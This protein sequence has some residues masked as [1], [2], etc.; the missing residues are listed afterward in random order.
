[1]LAALNPSARLKVN[2]DTFCIPDS[3]GSVYFRNNRV[4][5]R[6]EG[7]TIDQWIEKLIP[8]FHGGH[9]LGELT[10]G[11]PE[12]H[13]NQIYGIAET[14]YQNGFVRDVSG[15]LPHDLREPVLGRYASQIE[16]LDSLGGSGAHR[17]QAFRQSRVLAAG[18]GPMLVSLAAA[19]FESGL[20]RVHLLPVGPDPVNRPRLAE[21]TAHARRT[22]PEAEL[23]LTRPAGKDPDSWR[24]TI[25]PFDAVLYAAHEPDLKELRSLHAACRAERKALLPAIFL[26]QAGLAG[27]QVHPDSE[28]CWESAL[29]RL[30]R[31][32]LEKE[33]AQSPFSS[34]AG[35]LLANLI[36]FEWLKTAAGVNEP[37]R[38]RAF[39]LLDPETLEGEWHTF[40]PHPLAAGASA[41]A[42]IEKIGERLGP[43]T[44]REDFEA[45]RLL[46]YFASLTS[47]AAGILHLW[48]EEDLRQ[49]PLALC[50]V[51]AADPL[52]EGPAGLLPDTICSALTHEAARREAG[53]AGIEAYCARLAE[54]FA[55]EH[56]SGS[57]PAALAPDSRP[58]FGVG[59]G[60]TFA[61]GVCRGLSKCLA[62]LLGRPCLRM[63][64]VS[65]IR[66]GNVEDA[67]CRYFLRALAAMRGEPVI[68]LG[69]ETCG[70]PVVWIG[71]GGSW[72]KS[73]GL[74]LTLALRQALQQA[75]LELQLPS[76][77]RP[78]FPPPSAP[79]VLRVGR[80]GPG[81]DIPAFDDAG[82]AQLLRAALAV[83]ERNGRAIRVLDLALEPFLQETLAGVY[84]VQLH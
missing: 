57:A 23:V 29:R 26:G 33:T 16:F 80:E 62:E 55:A 53:L 39:F 41:P 42:W 8:V 13:R 70:F 50:R 27:P 63:P 20:P 37:E 36:V 7:R 45:G 30:H 22:D 28:A 38:E 64:A 79:A 71:S 59:A 12:E 19:L 32:A 77:R 44:S 56:L 25:R 58:A 74:N 68:G 54:R 75:L 84:G 5:F 66:L 78:A 72:F 46:P 83:L 10:E 65:R 34:T 67:G 82:H 31:P 11:L 6:M 17:F 2:R 14:L 73:A 52:A 48:D 81:L 76:E 51:Q 49:L 69:E 4:S 61:E 21:L 1:M 47:K 3:D 24:E 9:T 43:E 60:E 15:D 35:A 18:S 40:L